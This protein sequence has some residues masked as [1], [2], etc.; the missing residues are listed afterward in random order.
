M[1][2]VMITKKV[3]FNG[4]LVADEEVK[5]YYNEGSAI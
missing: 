2:A 3:K 5:A 1:N 4:L